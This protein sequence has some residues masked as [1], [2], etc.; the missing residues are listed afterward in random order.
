[1][2]LNSFKK[3]YQ[4]MGLIPKPSPRV[5]ANVEPI[6]PVLKPTL[7]LIATGVPQSVPTIPNLSFERKDDETES[8]NE[9]KGLRYSNFQRTHAHRPQSQIPESPI[10]TLASVA[11]ATSPTFDNNSRRA[12]HGQSSPQFANGY[13]SY[14]QNTQ[15]RPLPQEFSNGAI[16]RPS[17]RARS[18]AITLRDLPQSSSSRPAT[19]YNP[20]YGLSQNTEASAKVSALSGVVDPRT[21]GNEAEN[22]DN[23][24][25]L[26]GS[27]LLDLFNG[28]GPP[29][30]GNHFPSGQYPT[31]VQR[32]EMYARTNWVRP[33]FD[34]SMN[35]TSHQ[36]SEY[37]PAKDLTPPDSY[38]SVPS[39]GY[40][41]N[42]RTSSIIQ[43]HTPPDESEPPR[44]D[45]QEAHIP[46]A[47]PPPKK[48]HQGWPKGKPR[49]PRTKAGTSKRTSKTGAKARVGRPPGSTTRQVSA[50]RARSTGQ[51]RAEMMETKRELEN[52][53][54]TRRKSI[55]GLSSQPGATSEAP[56]HTRLASAPPEVTPSSESGPQK[57]DGRQRRRNRNQDITTCA[58]C[59]AKPSTSNGEI[60]SWLECNGCNQ[61]FHIACAGFKN[62]RE[63]RRVDKF[64][65]TDCTPKKGPTT[66][67]RKSSRAQAAVDYAGLN[68][69]VLRPTEDN[70]HEHHYI[71]PIKEGTLNYS[72]DQFARI[73]P[74]LVT[75]E[76]F[77]KC[78]GMKEPFVVPA[79]WNPRPTIPGTRRSPEP[80]EGADAPALAEENP[81]GFSNEELDEYFEFDYALDEGQDKIGMVIPE[82]LTVR[83]VAQLYGEH[84]KLDVIDV[85]SQE[86]DKVWTLSRWADY[87]EA[88]GEKP[89]RNVISLEVSMSK[90]G[91]LLKR[92]T[93]A[94]ELDLQEE[95]WP[96]EEP[97]PNVQFY[98]LMSV[99]DCYTDFHIDFGGSSVFY[100]IIKGRKTFFFIPPTKQN[101]KKYE[102][103][104]SSPA[105]NWTWL[106]DA[107]NGECYRVDLYPGDTAFIPSG[108]IHSVWTP[109]DSLVIGGNFLT[110][111]SYSMQLKILEIEKAT[112]VPQRFR[113]PFFQKVLW[114]AVMK[115]LETDPV[116]EVVRDLFLSKQVFPRATPTYEEPNKFGL[117][118]DHGPENYNARYYSKAELDGLPDLVGYIFRTVMISLGRVEGIKAE[119]RNAVCRSIPKSRL[120][121]DPLESIRLFAMWVAWKRGNEPI[122]DWAHPDSTLPGVEATSN[123]E[124]G[125]Q[126][127]SDA[128]LKRLE[129]MATRPIP[130]RQGARRKSKTKAE[131]PR[132]ERATTP[133]PEQPPMASNS[134]SVPESPDA[135]SKHVASPKTSVLGP[136]RIAC[137]A[138][139]KR[140]IRCKHKDELATP[141]GTKDSQLLQS[142]N[143][144]VTNRL[145]A[146]VVPSNGGQPSSATGDV[147]TTSIVRKESSSPSNGPQLD[148]GMGS[149]PDSK[150][151]RNRACA[152]CRVSKRRCIHDENGNV[153][154]VKLNEKSI[155]RGSSGGKK[156]SAPTSE[157]TDQH[158]TK[159]LHFED[160]IKIPPEDDTAMF[161][162][163]PNAINGAFG[164]G[165]QV[166]ASVPPF[167]GLAT[168]N[169]SHGQSAYSPLEALS[170]LANGEL[171]GRPMHDALQMATPTQAE[172][173]QF[174]LTEPARAASTS[175]GTAPVHPDQRASDTRQVSDPQSLSRH[176]SRAIKPV[177]RF[178]PPKFETPHQTLARRKSMSTGTSA[179][180][181]KSPELHGSAKSGMSKRRP[182]AT[183]P[184]TA[185]GS[186]RRSVSFSGDL[187]A[188]A[189]VAS[190]AR[191]AAT[192][193]GVKVERLEEVIEEETDEMK[194]ER[195]AREL[196]AQDWGLRDRRK[197]R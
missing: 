144:T 191:Q 119:T 26:V 113:Y 99:A 132:V 29:G 40:S 167:L 142:D 73:P 17:K 128:A 146:M 112:K 69:G 109:E 63:V 39:N 20:P 185:R 15:R 14:A 87:Y 156:R 139:R 138:C 123:G 98:C 85:K 1:M 72:P 66:Y 168:E 189:N 78:G 25:L 103:W 172:I 50:P 96:E 49:G 93:A 44:L 110:R 77:E 45:N 13:F 131:S 105:Q 51:L 94:R 61:W 34:Q 28:G 120:D 175:P 181:S 2:A 170:A 195:L 4:L 19:S 174:T 161:D 192:D 126:K 171:E 37:R 159:R 33:E 101:L 55:S 74:E 6:S 16:E 183:S 169:G 182:S 155:P 152:T 114:Y 136:K 162:S 116:P 186:Q 107:C 108:W 23:D 12:S 124:T 56:S 166:G 179:A 141:P 190:M 57:A 158:P 111:L 197:S 154:V 24:D 157:D 48:S 117:N 3:E 88:E 134:G 178:A 151:G 153:D 127:I 165:D 71:K 7:N 32:L 83:R 59:K 104:S 58:G 62:E 70:E 43:T 84:E 184:T 194:S 10:D 121:L 148:A 5:T 9:S 47:A 160:D 54:R 145:V 60:V 130:E 180:R 90:L 143:A 177:D 102:E 46:H 22:H 196:A 135:M 79:A 133:A 137:D 42:N 52:K 95:V 11:L 149:S 35:P 41:L 65:C 31:A 129:R 163:T 122:P 21:A 67:L 86:T 193:F 27:I 125:Q 100:H 92:P 164:V 82:G 188:R 150:K 187:A 140:R 97:S 80:T 64:F 89:I 115:Y 36:A 118:S 173:G 106:G 38:N 8:E 76:Y 75:A 53:E 68:E 147:A 30:M 91:R 18:E 176:S 81:T